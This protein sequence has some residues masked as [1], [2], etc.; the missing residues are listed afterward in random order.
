MTAEEKQPMP[1]EDAYPEL[2]DEEIDDAELE[3]LVLEESDSPAESTP[4]SDFTPAQS[5]VMTSKIEHELEVLR[6]QVKDKEENYVR[7]YAD[8]ENFR[9][10][11]QR[12]KEDLAQLEKRKYILEILPVV[13]SFERA[14]QQLKLETEREQ[15]IHNS[16]QGVYRQLVDV[17]KKMGVSR[18]KCVGQPFDPNIHEAIASQPSSEVPE[19]SVLMEYQPGYKLGDWVIRHAMVMVST[20]AEETPTASEAPPSP[21]DP[22]E[23]S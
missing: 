12:E 10:R 9:R 16:Y 2:I 11:T 5:D 21:S 15:A 23:G 18:M 1:P 22:G 19:D 6:Q 17:L 3:K 8:F 13:D 7:L 20:R 14:Q 4:S